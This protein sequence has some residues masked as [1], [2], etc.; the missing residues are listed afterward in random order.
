MAEER[1]VVVRGAAE[2]GS[3][4]GDYSHSRDTVIFADDGSQ[5]AKFL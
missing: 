5:A 1:L 4:A 2:F 3:L